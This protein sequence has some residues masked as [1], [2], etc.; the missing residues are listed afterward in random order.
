MIKTPFTRKNKRSNE[1]LDLIHAEVCGSIPICA[2]DEG[3][4]YIYISSHL[5]M[6]ILDMVMCIW[7]NIN[8]NHFEGSKNLEIK[9]KKN[10]QERALRCFD[11]INVVNTWAK[12]LKII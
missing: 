9:L 12:N 8:L 2:I 4:I 7:W 1:L 10:K 3:Y 5:L 6:I 11:R